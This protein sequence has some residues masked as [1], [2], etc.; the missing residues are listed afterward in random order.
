MDRENVLE[1]QVKYLRAENEKLEA[2]KQRM[3]MLIRDLFHELRFY[4]DPDD[5]KSLVHFFNQGY[6]SGNN[7][8]VDL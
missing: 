4:A 5:E 8:E 7:G 1:E 2:S 3:K 6:K